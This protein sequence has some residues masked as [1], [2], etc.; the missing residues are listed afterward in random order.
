MESTI[1]AA[2]RLAL[3]LLTIGILAA[4]VT[5]GTLRTSTTGSVSHAGAATPAN[6]ATEGS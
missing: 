4:L 6:G 1:R 3:A 5:I 2:R